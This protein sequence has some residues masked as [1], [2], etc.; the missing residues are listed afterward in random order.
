MAVE[1]AAVDSVCVYCGSSTA[2]D[3]AYIE[4]ARAFGA[5]LAGAGQRLI[6]GGGGIG[7][8]GAVARGAHEAGGRVLG[9]MPE[10]L[11]SRE[12]LF[13]D[14]E[15]VVV[16]SMHERKMIMFEK[17]DAFV[18]LPGGLGTLEEL[19]EVWVARSLGMHTKP[20]V[21]CDPTGLLEPLHALVDHL[22]EAGFV[23]HDAREALL[24][25]GSAEEA[26]DLVEQHLGTEPLLVPGTEAV[27]VVE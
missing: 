3:P 9:V 27:E 10:F 14:V 4:A 15:T 25:A 16:Q 23:R 7:L 12:R 13:N 2:A 26:L 8:M 24:W 22:D 19:F 6:Y 20:V 1:S 5:A 17:A 18:V 21:V 11:L